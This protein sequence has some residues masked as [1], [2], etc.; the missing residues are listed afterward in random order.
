MHR[1]LKMAFALLAACLLWAGPVH[2]PASAADPDC[3]FGIAVPLGI[4]GYQDQLEES[5]ACAYL[6]WGYSQSPYEPPGV[7]YI[8]ML[9]VRDDLYPIDSVTLSDLVAANPGASWVIGNEPDTC[10]ENQDCV[11][12]ETY[13][14]RYY[15]LAGQI[16]ALDGTANIGFGSLVQ[17]SDLRLRYLERAWQEL[18]SLAG[19]QAA[20]EDLIDFWN[21][22][23]FILNE[24]PLEWGT[25]IPLGFVCDT[26]QGLCWDEGTSPDCSATPQLCWPIVHYTTYPYNETHDNAIFNARIHTLRTWMEARGLRSYPLWITEY[27]SLFPPQDPPGGP[28]LVNVSDA[29]TARFMVETLEFIRTE[30]DSIT[31][32]PGD[33]NRLVQRALW[34]SLN[35]HRYKFG[36]TLYD[37]DDNGRR[38]PVGD[39]WLF[40]QWAQDPPRAVLSVYYVPSLFSPG[41]GRVYL[42]RTELTL[43]GLPGQAFR[44]LLWFHI[45]EDWSVGWARQV[46][47]SY[48]SAPMTPS[49]ESALW[50]ADP[51]MCSYGGSPETGYKWEGWEGPIETLPDQAARLGDAVVIRGGLRVSDTEDPGEYTHVRAVVGLMIDLDGNGTPD[52][53]SCSGAGSSVVSVE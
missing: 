5:R 49:N 4:G 46:S 3:R 7:E 31:G 50:V 41:Q 52:S 35:E 47:T 23:A 17:P 12:P 51:G 36:G 15:D 18:I 21:V 16:R 32:N 30:T 48:G 42:M 33:G 22:H 40:D 25:G 43:E 2:G 1:S 45:P 19:S 11:T 24:W 6:D 39:A 8:Q 27:G 38:T 26:D 9:R 13:A 29:E 20:A 37:P 44:F 34:Y 14:A 10:Y 28:N 53:Y